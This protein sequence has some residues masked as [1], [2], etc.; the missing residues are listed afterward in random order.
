MPQRKIIL[1]SAS[2]RRAEL[3]RQTG[4]PFAIEVS[5][6]A[7]P[8]HTHLTPRELALRH[9][10]RKASAVAKTFPDAIV[11][12]ADTIVVLGGN[13]F[14]KPR[15][16][17]EAKRMLGRLQGRTHHVVTGVCVLDRKR[18]KKLLFTETTAVSFR[19][20]SAKQINSYLRRVNPLDKAGAYAIQEHGGEL[21]EKI[22]GSWSNVVGFPVEKFQK[23]MRR[24]GI[25]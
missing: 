24:A 12:G 9:A 18:R 25:L 23:L 6:Q 19:K 1:A 17:S 10:L 8:T 20:R 5:E 4:L 16:L 2:P 22:E 15:N 11:I 3:L 13:V 14:G 21:V 7:E